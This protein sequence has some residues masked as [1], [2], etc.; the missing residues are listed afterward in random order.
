MVGTGPRSVIDFSDY[1][2]DHTDEF[3]GREWVFNAVD[4]WLAQ[5]GESRFFVLIGEPGSGKTALAGRLNQFSRNEIHLPQGLTNLTPNFLSAVHFCSARDR[6]WINPHTFT[7]S[8]ALQ[9]ATRY[10]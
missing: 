9:L 8:L 10:P 2:A 1:V 7:K 3:T 4:D 6:R 5:S